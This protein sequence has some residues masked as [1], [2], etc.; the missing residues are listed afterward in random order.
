MGELL[1]R[2]EIAE[3]VEIIEDKGC[4]APKPEARTAGT[5]SLSC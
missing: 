2:K 5:A 3:K 1:R 4:K